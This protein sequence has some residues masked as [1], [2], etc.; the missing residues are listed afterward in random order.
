MK[1]QKKKKILN[2]VENKLIWKDTRCTLPL[3]KTLASESWF[4]Q[5][6]IPF[7]LF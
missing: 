1:I 3:I 7:D 4:Y 2:I 6:N 5:F